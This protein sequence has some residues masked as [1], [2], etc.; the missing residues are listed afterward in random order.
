MFGPNHENDSGY[1]I[2]RNEELFELL[3]GHV[4][5]EYVKFKRL[6]CASHINTQDGYY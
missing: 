3:N 4:M 1:R 6:P 5:V 2:R